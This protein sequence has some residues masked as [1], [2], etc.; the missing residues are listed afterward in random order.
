MLR[1]DGLTGCGFGNGTVLYTGNA[2]PTNDIIGVL[3]PVRER[4]T[5]LYIKESTIFGV[6]IL[7]GEKSTGFCFVG[8]GS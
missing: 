4:G 2:A 8:V 6:G 5:A 1:W 3:F 7:Y